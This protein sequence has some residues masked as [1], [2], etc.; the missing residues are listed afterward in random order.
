VRLRPALLRQIRRRRERG[1]KRARLWREGAAARPL[2]ADGPESPID[3][4]HDS[5][6]EAQLC[7]P[8]P[9]AFARLAGFPAD[10]D[11]GGPGAAVDPRD[12]PRAAAG[13]VPRAEADGADDP[14]AEAARLLFADGA[15]SPID[16]DHDPGSEA[17]LCPPLPP[18]FAG[19]TGFPADGALADPGAAVR[20]VPRAEADGARDAPRAGA[21]DR[22]T[23]GS[24]LDGTSAGHSDFDVGEL[25]VEWADERPAAGTGA[26][27]R[28]KRRG[29]RAHA[30]APVGPSRSTREGATT[31]VARAAVEV[32]V[33]R[34]LAPPDVEAGVEVMMQGLRVDTDLNGQSG[35]V[36]AG[37]RCGGKVPVL[38][39]DGECRV[40]VPARCL[41]LLEQLEAC[42]PHFDLTPA[43]LA[44]WISPHRDRDGSLLPRS[45]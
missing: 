17:Q 18:A 11:L 4:D 3:H 7:P 34:T 2:F 27:P 31:A 38:L 42:A 22:S 36:C 1:A 25:A 8:L 43:Q 28:R 41:Y 15:E 21:Q 12:D 33:L 16:H 13:D 19:L 10:G 35:T 29:K 44:A 24:D 37:P 40:R 5:G 39:R 6:S 45:A 9:L 30:A 14:R 20:E 32:M 26:P 23:D